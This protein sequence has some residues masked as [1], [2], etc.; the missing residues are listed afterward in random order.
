VE[1]LTPPSLGFPAPV[2]E[3]LLGGDWF[4]EGSVFDTGEQLA[5]ALLVLAGGR[6]RQPGGERVLPAAPVSIATRP[7]HPGG[8]AAGVGMGQEAADAPVLDG[9]FQVA[10][11]PSA[12]GRE[13]SGWSAHPAAVTRRRWSGAVPG[14]ERRGWSIRQSVQ[15]LRLT[16]EILSRLREEAAQLTWQLAAAAHRETDV[17]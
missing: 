14:P 2:A 6:T 5:S 7:G 3:D 1:A 13:P 17:S 8:N 9:E 11:M 12:L 4:G 16:E 10:T 15:V